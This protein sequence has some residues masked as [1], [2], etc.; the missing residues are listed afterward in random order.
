MDDE[1][2]RNAGAD[3]NA[4]IYHELLH[5]L[6]G[7]HVDVASALGLPYNANP[8]PGVAQPPEEAAGLRDMA[9]GNAINQFLKN[10]C[11][12]PTP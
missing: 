5:G 8:L 3:Q 6:L 10:D 9:A 1:F 4:A 2:P 11:K 12:K 7:S